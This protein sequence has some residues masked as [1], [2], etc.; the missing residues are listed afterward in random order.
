MQVQAKQQLENGTPGQ[1][2]YDAL[3]RE[4]VETEQDLQRLQN[5]ASKISSVLSKI[6]ETGEK[7]EKVGDSITSAGNRKVLKS[8]VP[9]A[10]FL[11]H[12]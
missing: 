4:I 7:F 1:D 5:E 9:P 6:D 8:G 12:R 3:Q 2:K 11:F 10:V